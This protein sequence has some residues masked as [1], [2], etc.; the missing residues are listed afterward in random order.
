M[1]SSASPSSSPPASA[2]A[3]TY[4]ALWPFIIISIAYLLF[5]ITDGA[6]RMIVLLHAYTKGFTAMEVATM[7][8]LYELMGA[9]TNLAAGVAGARW[10]IR[11]TLLSGLALQIAGLGALF[12]W[13]DDWSKAVA[14][15]YVT[16]AQALC[17]VAKDLTKLGGKTVTKLVTPEEKQE[18]LFKLVSGL[19]GYKNA[20]KGVGYFMGAA[21]LEVSYEAALGVNVGFI[22][23]ATPFAFFG[24]TDDLGRVASKNI[25]LDAVFRQTGNINRLSLARL[26]L[27]GSRDLWFEV[28]L[29]F[30]LRSEE[31]L[32]W[33]RSAVGAMLAGYII[34]YGLCQSYAPQLA[35]IPLGQ[36]P[37]NKYVCALWNA[38]LCVAPAYLL[39]VVRSPMYD[40]PGDENAGKVGT[41][42]FG[43]F[44]FA[45]VFA[46]NSA[47]HS[48][49]VVKYSDGNKVAMN[50][51]FYYM[52]NAFGRL[53]GTIASG[54]LY[55]YA[56]SDPNEG[57]AAC[58]AASLAFSVVT[59]ALAA[60]I[61][62]DE[63][64]LRWG[65]GDA[66]RCF[67]AEPWAEVEARRKAAEEAKKE[68]EEGE[69]V[70][71]GRV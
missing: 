21:L 10:G 9:A 43:V 40:T 70:V 25:T 29:P 67:G 32:G 5:T 23:I 53:I 20:L 17:G 56:S 57:L 8:A 47:V 24:L 18:T 49:L 34:A 2:K 36:S 38:I 1:S 54:V 50:V 60:R 48:Y 58:F 7:F 46:V 69:V 27:F 45:V 14:V 35:L 33:P 59:T 42:L 71:G 63:G 51:G 55:T 61:D 3:S 37:P 65:R 6:V 30:Y 19:T 15:V 28:P 62:D 31:G 64:G 52:A 11:A 41:L 68:E 44:G 22:V 4:G 16:A 39:C 13:D 66:L 12:A 26:F